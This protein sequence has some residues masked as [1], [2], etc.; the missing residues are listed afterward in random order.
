[1]TL[2]ISET[3]QKRNRY[4]DVGLGAGFVGLFLIVVHIAM[5][6]GMLNPHLLMAA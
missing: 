6:F 3:A 4:L 1:V 2:D 5:I